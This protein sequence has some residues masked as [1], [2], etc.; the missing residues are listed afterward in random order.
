MAG[1][2]NMF[3]EWLDS[4]YSSPC[5]SYGN[6]SAMRVSPI[7]FAY[8]SLDIIMKEAGKSAAV[9][10]DHPEGIKGAQAVA[11][12]IFLARNGYSNDAIRRQLVLLN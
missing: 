10:H 8:S 12:A 1:Y 5:D 7:G 2:G 11:A 9:T 3:A 6:G 4:D